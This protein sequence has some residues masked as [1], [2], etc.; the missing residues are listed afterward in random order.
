MTVTHQRI[1][2]RR[3]LIQIE[4]VRV[5]VL[6][7]DSVGMSDYL[8]WVCAYGTD[9]LIELIQA[10]LEEDEDPDGRNDVGI[11][12]LAVTSKRR[13]RVFH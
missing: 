10:R 3:K 7:Q 9:A 5:D 12:T 6:R 1:A 13:N 2:K 8:E 11:L 4:S